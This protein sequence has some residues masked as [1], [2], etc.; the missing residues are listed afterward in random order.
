[1]DKRNYDRYTRGMN[2]TMTGILYDYTEDG[3]TVDQ[4]ADR[5]H[6]NPKSI[7][8]FLRREGV[9]RKRGGFR[10]TVTFAGMRLCAKC[11]EEKPL[12]EFHKD[13]AQSQG[14]GYTCKSCA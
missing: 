3:M 9:L 6:F 8:E 1:M 11:K 4:L 7:R 12:E 13:R 5:Y 2:E 14:Y 10:P